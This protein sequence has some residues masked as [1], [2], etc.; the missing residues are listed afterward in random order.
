MALKVQIKMGG[1]KTYIEYFFS[2]FFF[3]KCCSFGCYNTD[4][5][6][7]INFFFLFM[8]RWPSVRNIAGFEIMQP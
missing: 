5:I 6:K 1:G 4:L 7:N 2:K 8:F 3:L